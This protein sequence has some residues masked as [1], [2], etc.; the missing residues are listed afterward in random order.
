MG[1]GGGGGGNTSTINKT[2]THKGGGGGGSTSI[3]NIKRSVAYQSEELQ[4]MYCRNCYDSP[5]MFLMFTR[6]RACV[7]RRCRRFHHTR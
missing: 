2:H 4:R 6:L 1:G 5:T 3:G 7:F